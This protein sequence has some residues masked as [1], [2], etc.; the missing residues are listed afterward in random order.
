[1]CVSV[2]GARVTGHLP[3]QQLHTHTHTQRYL[4]VTGPTDC[5]PQKDCLWQFG[6]SSSSSTSRTGI[7]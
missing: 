7:M 3:V 6:S 1:V 4:S 5:Q 2:C